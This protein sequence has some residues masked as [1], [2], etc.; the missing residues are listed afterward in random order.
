MC[1]TNLDHLQEGDNSPPK[2][3]VEFNKQVGG[4]SKF[5]W[6]GE[7]MIGKPKDTRE[8]EFYKRRPSLLKKYL[9]RCYGIIEGRQ[10]FQQTFLRDAENAM[11]HQEYM[12]MENLTSQFENPCVLDLKMGTRMHGDSA[13]SAKIKS[14]TKKCLNST[15]ASLGV[16]C[17][18]SLWFDPQS[19]KYERQDKYKGR[20]YNAQDFEDALCRFVSDGVT[21]R[22]DVVL[23]LISQLRGL[24]KAI[25]SLDSHRFYG[26]SLLIVYEGSN[27]ESDFHGN[28][29]SQERLSEGDND[30]EV[31]NLLAQGGG[32][33]PQPPQTNNVII[34]MID[35]AH[36][37][38]K[39]FM[40]DPIVHSGPD[41]GY[42][43]GLETLISVLENG[44]KSGPK[45][46]ST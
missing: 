33:D 12:I 38:F 15:S 39:G 11:L 24:Q 27:F 6:I 9:P 14:Q 44:L 43:R 36:S 42:L 3:P 10:L 18:G 41:K 29:H 2:S 22:A 35:F 28:T 31:D 46:K 17:C 32:G 19:G 13:T 30:E 26:S 25:S 7:G 21:L 1:R 16:R 4:H 34:K 8:A 45:L 23:L 37:T 20:K 5:L 40:D